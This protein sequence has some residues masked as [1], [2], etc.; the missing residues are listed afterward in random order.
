VHVKCHDK[1]A[2]YTFDRILLQAS[3][4][5]Q[6]KEILPESETQYSVFMFGVDAVS[7]LAG[8]RKLPWGCLH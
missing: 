5:T 1:R 4:I 3:K 2:K 7:R 6:K 8:I